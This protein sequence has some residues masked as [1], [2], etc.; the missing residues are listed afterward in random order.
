LR[1]EG[2]GRLPD[3]RLVNVANPCDC[4]VCFS[5][6]ADQTRFG[7]GTRNRPL[8]PFVSVAV[9]KKLKRVTVHHGGKRCH[10][11]LLPASE[12]RI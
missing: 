12:S 1:L 3:G 10:Q 7:T 9:A 5:V 2:S 11:A 6:V 8:S 4:G